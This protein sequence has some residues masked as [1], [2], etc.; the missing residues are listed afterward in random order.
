VGLLKMLFVWLVLLISIFYSVVIIME[1]T[2][3]SYELLLAEKIKSSIEL[4][5]QISIKKQKLGIPNNVLIVAELYPNE[6]ECE[7]CV[8]WNTGNSKYFRINIKSKTY[9]TLSHEIYHAYRLYMQDAP[10][11]NWL[12]F[13]LVEE[14]LAIIYSH[15]ELDFT[16]GYN[17]K[18]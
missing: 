9:K 5:N 7:N 4:E 15:T 6:R 14:P 2:F 11:Q 1:I 16:W 13:F 18:P 17:K 10:Q 8:Q 3:M 12:S